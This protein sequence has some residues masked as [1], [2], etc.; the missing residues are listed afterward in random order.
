MSGEMKEDIKFNCDVSD[1]RYWG[2]FS[3]CGLLM[4]YRDLYRSEQG[5]DPWSSLPREDIAV[6]I[7]RKESSWPDLEGRPFRQI[8]AGDR[9]FDPFDSDGINEVLNPEGYVYG[10]GYGMFRKPT[11]FLG[12][13][14]ASAEVEGH[15]VYTSDKEPVRDLLAAPAMLQD[16]TIYLRLDPLRALLW[17]A[18]GRLKQGCDPVLVDA[19]AAADIAPGRAADR[20]FTERLDRMTAA[21]SEVLLWHELS[22]SRERSPRWKDLIAEADDRKTELILRAIQD[23]VADTGESGPFR[24]II[25]RRDHGALASLIGLTEGYRRVLFPG[26]REAYRRFVADRNWT[27]LEDARKEG[28]VLLR[29]NRRS[30]LEAFEAGGRSAFQ[31]RLREMIGDGE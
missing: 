14:K 8:A 17:D 6:W 19:F 7:E 15:R 21:Y 10:A 25:E 23:L 27:I 18:F 16:R 3:I 28:Y 26:M 20:A 31:R 5:L 2:H 4:R 24:R 1:A 12:F 9:H 30:A 13:L 11:F 22:E 29:E